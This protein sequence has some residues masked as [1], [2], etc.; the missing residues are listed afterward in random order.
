MGSGAE[1][2]PFARRRRR[3]VAAGKP[4]KRS[5]AQRSAAVNATAPR[6][7]TTRSR[8]RGRATSADNPLAEA[9]WRSSRGCCHPASSAR[10]PSQI[11]AGLVPDHPRAP[12]AVTD[13]RMVLRADGDTKVVDAA[14][15]TGHFGRHGPPIPS[16]IASRALA[17]LPQRKPD[18]SAR[19]EAV[20][21][22]RVPAGS[23]P[24]RSPVSMPALPMRCLPRS[25]A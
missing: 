3:R 1:R 11:V 2:S 9:G 22:L 23:P 13:E 15:E 6:P 14:A 21:H 18:G 25:N 7:A 20:T 4:R 16:K 8:R 17:T 10:R 24:K 12:A 5:V 19:R